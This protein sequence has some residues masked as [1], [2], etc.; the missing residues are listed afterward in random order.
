MRLNGS[1]AAVQLLRRSGPARCRRPRCAMRSA[2]RGARRATSMRPR[3]RVLH[4]VADQ[5]GEDLARAH[6]VA[7]GRAG[8]GG[9][10]D[11]GSTMTCQLQPLGGGLRARGSSAPARAPGRPG[12]TAPRR[13]TQARRPRRSRC[14]GWRSARRSGLRRRPAPRPTA[15]ATA[16]RARPPAA[17]ASTWATPV[18]PLRISCAEGGDEVGLR[19]GQPFGL[20]QRAV[21]LARQLLALVGQREQA[22]QQCG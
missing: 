4:R 1:N 18:R 22:A 14:R 19:R 16:A 8:L 15:R 11:A 9:C 3:T 5:V 2:R 12:R 20:R 10:P 7:D 13:P 17:A 6:R 21:A